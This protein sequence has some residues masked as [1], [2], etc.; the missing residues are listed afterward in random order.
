MKKKI[1]V[2]DDQEELLE[3]TKRVLQSRGYDV[4]TLV[5]GEEALHTRKKESPDHILM[6]MLMP[7]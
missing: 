2:I 4:I 5:D 1:L 7:G 3:L 6:V